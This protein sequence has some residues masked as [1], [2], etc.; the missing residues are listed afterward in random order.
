MLLSYAPPFIFIHIDKSAG[1]SIQ[2]ALQHYSQPRRDRRLRRRMTLLG[3]INRVANL[4]RSLEFPEHVTAQTVK[5]CL[6]PE[7]Y[8]TAFK[9]AF[10]RNPWDRLVSRYAF[11]LDNVGH[12][13]HRMVKRMRRFEDYVEWEIRQRRMFQ[14][15]YVT[16]PNNQL[17]V[18]F[19]GYYE[20]LHRDFEHVCACLGI[21][22]ELPHDNA[23]NHTEYRNYYTPASRELVAE[24]FRHDIELFGY[25][26]DGLREP[27][28]AIA[29]ARR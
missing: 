8:S 16:G 29:A 20:R 9:F 11:L 22:A 7:L 28:P 12:P 27:A 5:Q 3:R 23:S 2:L 10:V 4:Y 25:D 1:S 18:D 6:P 13:E 19:I 17:I 14:C 15:D 26:F 21:E 24:H